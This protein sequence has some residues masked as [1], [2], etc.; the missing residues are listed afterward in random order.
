MTSAFS[1]MVAS[2]ATYPHEVIRSYMHV[3]GGRQQ[4]QLTQWLMAALAA[5]HSLRLHM[6][7]RCMHAC[8]QPFLSHTLHLGPPGPW[9]YHHAQRSIM[10]ARASALVSTAHHAPRTPGQRGDPAA[11]CPLQAAGL[12]TA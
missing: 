6:R 5:C 8:R 7:R 3:T 10:N 2:T 12:S 4:Q 9:P 11:A 1:K